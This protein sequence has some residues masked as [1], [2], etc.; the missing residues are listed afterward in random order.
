M[1]GAMTKST[2]FGFLIPAVALLCVPRS[3]SALPPGQDPR[4]LPFVPP[5]AEIV[6]GFTRKQQVS[7]LVVTRNNVTDLL[8]LESISGVDPSRTFGAAIVIAASGKSGSLSEHSLVASG[9]FDASHIFKAAK[10]NGATE[11]EYLGIPVLMVPPLHRDKGI[12]DDVRL[13]AVIGSQ[14]AVFG[15]IP[16]VREELSRY[17]VRSPADPSLSRD[18]SRLRSNDQ[19]WCVLSSDIYRID[20]IRRF[21]ALL[22]PTLAQAGFTKDRVIMGIHFGKQI[23]M[24]YEGVPDSTNTGDQPQ[25]QSD[26]SQMLRPDSALLSS[27]FVSSSDTSLHKVI[28]FSRKQYN[29]LIAQEEAGEQNDRRPEIAISR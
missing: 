23:E 21:L 22:D 1:G 3:A 5:G 10:E 25:I 29:Q 28:R 2:L 12:S 20:E 9:Q 19:S 7:L 14:I 6:V 11:T 8:D 24:E 4:L 16:M 15:T 26:V 13:F 27:H 17:L 18:V